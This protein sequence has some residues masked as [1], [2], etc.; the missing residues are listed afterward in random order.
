M[1]VRK[2]IKVHH[3]KNVT[4]VVSHTRTHTSQNRSSNE[5]ILIAVSDAQWIA[6]WIC[7][8]YKFFFHQ[9]GKLD[10]LKN[11]SNLRTK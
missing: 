3:V 11:H 6:Y 5:C 8:E 2:R 1:H 4:H 9:S 7:K 10:V